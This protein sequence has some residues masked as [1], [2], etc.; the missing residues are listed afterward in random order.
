MR[1]QIVHAFAIALTIWSVAADNG[2]YTR[3]SPSR[4]SIV[5]DASGQHQGSYKTVSAGITALRNTTS[6]QTIF[7]LPGT[8]TEQVYV[9]PL[10][11]PLTVQGYTSDA[12]SYKDNTVTITYNLSR[13]TPGLANNDAT[14]T[15]R[16]W[17]PN[18]KF[19]NLNIY[20]TFGQAA[21]SGQALALS[22]QKTNQGFYGCKFTGYQD[23]IYAN[24]GRQIYAK[25]YINGAVDFIF[26][27]RA[28]AWFEDV[29]I[30]S[31]G[32]GYITA[33]GRE[34]QNNTS[35]YVINQSKVFGSSPNSTVLGRPW[36]TF[37]RVVFQKSYLGDVVKPEGWA[38]WDAVQSV[39]N[40]VYQ[41]YK[42]FGPG[43]GLV[44]RAN[45]S[46]QIERAYRPVDLFGKRFESEGWVD[47][48]YL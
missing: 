41:E 42:N 38:R 19:Y 34:A 40:V 10:G 9:P 35:I 7:I 12:R 8:Y 39:E 24:E 13:K 21:T 1:S 3:A 5:V 11:G 4:G 30:E 48:D 46:T 26:G 29:D 16:L 47:G 33:N 32:P 31:I 28:I 17:T 45:F 25:S 44:A 15:V 37:S 22:A 27:L 14:A 36:R 20:N 43:A 18:V 6:A 2:K 23:T